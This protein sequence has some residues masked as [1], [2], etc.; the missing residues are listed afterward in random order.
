MPEALVPALE[1]L[2]LGALARVPVVSVMVPSGEQAPV[3]AWGPE[4]G[5]GLERVQEPV[6]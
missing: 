2:V 3:P 1:V 5:S 4:R 6:R